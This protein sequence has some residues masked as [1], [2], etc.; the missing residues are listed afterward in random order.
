MA[1]DFCGNEIQPGD[2]VIYLDYLRTSAELKMGTVRQCAEHSA[3]ICP[4]TQHSVS[5]TGYRAE[6]KIVDLTALR[7]EWEAHHEA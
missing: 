5:Q 2:L 4:H 6:Y 1:T 7:R 3:T